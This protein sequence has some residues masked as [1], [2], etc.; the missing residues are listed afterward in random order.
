[1]VAPAGRCHTLLDVPW[2]RLQAGG[3]RTGSQDGLD[4][5]ASILPL[6][7]P[8]TDVSWLEMEADSQSAR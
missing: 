4:V 2:I 7:H 1:M 8:C 3:R 5:D 6:W